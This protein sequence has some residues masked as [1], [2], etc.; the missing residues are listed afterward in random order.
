MR[1][2]VKP[3][4]FMCYEYVLL[5]VDD[6]ICIIND[7][8]HTIKGI[9]SKFKLKGDKIEEPDM[10]LDTELSNITNVDGQEC[11]YMSSDKYFTA[12][13]TNVES[14]F[15]K[16]WFKVAAKLCYPSELC[17]LSKYGCYRRYQGGC[18]PML[19]ITHGDPEMGSAN[20]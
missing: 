10:Y 2:S 6:V 8:L 9:Q 16:T 13:V 4:G 7:Q 20:W 19:P 1:P 14:I 11:W 15:V 17:L 3:S 12:A 5:F 18:S